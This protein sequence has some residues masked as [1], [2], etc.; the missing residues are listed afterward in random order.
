MIE[1][2]RIKYTKLT[3]IRDVGGTAVAH[4]V[5]VRTTKGGEVESTSVLVTSNLMFNSADVT[6]ADFTEQRLERGL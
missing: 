1:G 3:D 6:E 5:T 2:K 4:T